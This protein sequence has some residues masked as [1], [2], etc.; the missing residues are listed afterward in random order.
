[1]TDTDITVDFVKIT[2]EVLD[3]QTIVDI[4]KDNG[5]GAISTF[6]GTTRD[7][8][9][10]KK[11]IKLDYEAYIPMAEKVLLSIISEARSKWELKKIAVYH[12][13]GTVP[14]GENS[15]IIAVSSVHRKESLQS[16]EWLINQLKEK[17]P[18]WKKEIYSDGSVWKENRENR[19]C[20]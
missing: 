13:L 11:V 17:A 10:D 16:V 3:L 18:I 14:V 19:V 2:S 12:R 6:S 5:A 20:C 15:V 7:T 4:V 9:R 1:M 8:Y